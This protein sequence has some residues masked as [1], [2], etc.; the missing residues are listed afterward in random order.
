MMGPDMII[1]VSHLL[2][3]MMSGVAD[4]L[5]WLDMFNQCL[6]VRAV[7][8]HKKCGT[9]LLLTCFSLPRVKMLVP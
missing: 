5:F 8:P 1:A 9:W 6:K 7:G 4:D 2:S 3:N